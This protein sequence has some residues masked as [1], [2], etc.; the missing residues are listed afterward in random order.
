MQHLRIGIHN[1]KC[2]SI[3][4]KQLLKLRDGKNLTATK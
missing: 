3:E 1:L 2:N 4:S